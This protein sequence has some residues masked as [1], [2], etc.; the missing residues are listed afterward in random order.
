MPVDSR[1]EMLKYPGLCCEWIFSGRALLLPAIVPADASAVWRSDPKENKQQRLQY[2]QRHHDPLGWLLK[3]LLGLFNIEV[4]VQQCDW[5]C[6][7][8]TGL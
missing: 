1:L 8:I 4:F 3:K 7:N 2:H 6:S 5:K